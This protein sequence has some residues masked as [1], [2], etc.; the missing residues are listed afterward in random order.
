MEERWLQKKSS[1]DGARFQIFEPGG[2]ETDAE[3]SVLENFWQIFWK[4]SG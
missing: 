2:P 4:I 3:D 1:E